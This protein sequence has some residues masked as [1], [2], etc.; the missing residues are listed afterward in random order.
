MASRR[1]FEDF[2]VGQ[3][4][5]GPSWEV[6]AGIGPAEFPGLFGDAGGTVVEARWQHLAPVETGA[7]VRFEDTVTRCRRTRDGMHGLVTRH[8]CVVD[9]RGRT[10][11]E[12][13]TT[14]RVPARGS[15]P[16]PAGR[17][18]ATPEWAEALA[19]LLAAD[20]RFTEATATW[21]G[22]IGLRCGAEEVQLRVY[23]GSVLR[24]G[25]RTPLGATF[26]LGA[27]ELTWTE[28]LTGPDNDFIRRAMSGQFDVRG[29]GYEYLRLTKVLDILVDNA[30][31]L[32]RQDGAA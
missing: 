14:V 25:T 7:T 24:P 3:R 30:R 26:T 6:T 15:G 16:D 1:Y 20:G 23:C 29:N 13:S 32:A 18:F 31:Q 19:G 2:V 22:A 8:G 12:G 5:S 21:D 28:L 17:A 9:R 11:C 10:V 4:S 27:T